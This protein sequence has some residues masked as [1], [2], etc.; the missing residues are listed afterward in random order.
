MFLL[1]SL[2]F[3]LTQNPEESF[4]R[5]QALRAEATASAYSEAASLLASLAGEASLDPLTRFRVELNLC[6]VYLEA[7]QQEAAAARL[8]RVIVP[9]MILASD[10]AAYLQIQ[11]LVAR[12][13]GELSRSRR[14][15]REAAAGVQ[16]PGE[17]IPLVNTAIAFALE[18]YELDEAEELTLRLKKLAAGQSGIGLLSAAPSFYLAQIE[19]ARGHLEG[20]WQWLETHLGEAGDAVSLPARHL[21]CDLLEAR[22]QRK[23]ARA[24]RR[25]LPASAEAAA[26]V[27]VKQLAAD[28]AARRTKPERVSS[29][30]G[31]RQGSRKWQ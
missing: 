12:H 11:A 6:S 20:A 4:R 22:G 27:S 3:L 23:Q 24:L 1:T 28:S 25:S 9:G 5:A 30:P 31:G 19:F 2:L 18:D 10:R 26:W 15:L 13:A 29:V 17:E 7:G 16:T 21:H 8:A 14:L